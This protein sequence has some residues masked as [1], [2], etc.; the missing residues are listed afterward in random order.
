MT[1]ASNIHN[2]WLKKVWVMAALVALILVSCQNDLE[3]YTGTGVTLYPAIASHVDNVIRTRGTVTVQGAASNDVYTDDFLG[4]GTVI[5]VYAAPNVNDASLRAA[6]SFRYNNDT[7]RSSVS[8]N[9]DGNREFSVYAITPTLLPGA[10]DQT[11]NWGIFKNAQLQ[12]TLSLDSAALSFT[13]LDIITTSDPMVCI[14]AAGQSS[15]NSSTPTLQKGYFNIGQVETP[16]DDKTWK[17]WMAFNHLYSKCTILFAIDPE[18]HIIRDIRLKSAKIVVTNGKLAGNHTYT[19][20]KGM[21]L[22][23][24]AHFATKKLEIELMTGPTANENRDSGMDYATLTEDYKEYASFCF[25]PVSYLSGLEY[26]TVQLKVEYDIYNRATQA[27]EVRGGQIATNKFDLTSFRRSNDAALVPP[28][29]GDHFIVKLK[30]KPSY[31]AQMIDD[32]AEHD[33]DILTP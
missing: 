12:D 23:N 29:P 1:N 27:I 30:I 15:E 16:S 26:P 31:I 5:R 24:T 14:A 22:D 9:A 2:A 19:F 6:G 17:V 13:D 3:E 18:Y 11:F 8:V 33:F 28:E 25:L 20:T 32:D 4:N 7:W 21:R 10:T